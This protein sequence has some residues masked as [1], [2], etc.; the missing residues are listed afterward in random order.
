MTL[1]EKRWCYADYDEHG[2]SKVVVLSEKEILARYWPYWYGKMCEKYGKEYIDL[3]Y[4]Q[5]DCIDDW[6]VVNW[7]W[8]SDK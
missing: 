2:D 1:L 6:I 3:N 4:S 8:E 5:E 7:A